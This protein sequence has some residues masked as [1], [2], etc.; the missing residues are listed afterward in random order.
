MRHSPP[1]PALLCCS[2]SGSRPIE[3]GTGKAP[4]TSSTLCQRSRFGEAAACTLQHRALG[5]GESA[6]AQ[7]LI[8][9]EKPTHAAGRSCHRLLKLRRATTCRAA[10]AF[11]MFR[12]SLGV[13]R[14]PRHTATTAVCSLMRLC[15]TGGVAATA[16]LRGRSV[17][18][19]F[20]PV[21]WCL[22]ASA[23]VRLCTVAAAC[24]ISGTQIQTY[25]MVL[26]IFCKC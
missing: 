8:V 13:L 18:L 17:C 10:S 5:T 19:P 24:P 14:R 2:R 16:C 25:R 21:W 3:L 22:L 1:C 9:L 15:T 7:L 20:V 4:P 12:A 26:S 23:P 11:S 6:V